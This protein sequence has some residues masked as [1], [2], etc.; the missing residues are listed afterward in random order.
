MLTHLS[1]DELLHQILMLSEKL[2]VTHEDPLA[3]GALLGD[4]VLDL[5]LL[6]QV[7][8]GELLSLQS[9]F[10]DLLHFHVLFLLN[11]L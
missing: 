3:G 4:L 8:A 5:R 10:L 6:L 11:L 9:D 2:V 7:V 1:E